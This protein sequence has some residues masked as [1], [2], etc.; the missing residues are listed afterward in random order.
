MKLDLFRRTDGA[1]VV[2]PSRFA[3]GLPALAT[4]GLRYIRTVDQELAVLGDA[5][6]L[7]IGLNGFAVALGADAALL[8]SSPSEDAISA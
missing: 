3:R 4:A 6:V 1:L 5:L 8:R 2:V 7:D